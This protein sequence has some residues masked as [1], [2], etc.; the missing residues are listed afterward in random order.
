MLAADRLDLGSLVRSTECATFSTCCGHPCGN[1][2]IPTSRLIVA[3]SVIFRCISSPQP[4]SLQTPWTFLCTPRWAG[5]RWEW[6]LVQTDS[7]HSITQLL[8]VRTSRQRPAPG[9][10]SLR[11][12][13]D[14]PSFLLISLVT[15]PNPVCLPNSRSAFLAR[16]IGSACYGI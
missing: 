3:S 14:A 8:L 16:L 6:E 12:A 1:T 10:P 7:P 2:S 4:T 9:R 15:P 5:P 11:N 13:C